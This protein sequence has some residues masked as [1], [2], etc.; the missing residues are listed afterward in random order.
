MTSRLFI[1]CLLA[2]T[3]NFFI[4]NHLK[5]QTDFHEDSSLIVENANE[6]LVK[7][8]RLKDQD[9][10]IDFLGK[11]TKKST[12]LSI[13]LI[14]FY[15]ARF[16]YL[17][18]NIPKAIIIANRNIEDNYNLNNS[19]AK[20]NNI[21]GAIY[22]LKKEY[23]NAIQAFLKAAKGYQKQGNILREHVIYNNIANIYLALGDHQQ[24]YNYSEL[25]FSEYRAFPENPNYL[26]FL[27]MLIICENNLNMLDSAKVHIDMGL[28]LLN[29]TKDIQGKII[30]NFAKSEWEYKNDNFHKAI[31]FAL[32]SLKISDQYNLKQFQIMSEILLMDIHNLLEEYSLALN[33]GESA[34]NNLKYY[35]NSSMKHSISNGLATSYAGLGEFEKAYFYKNETDSLKTIDRDV[36]NK[37]NMDSLLVEFETSEAQNELLRKEVLI[38]TKDKDIEERNNLIIF[39][40][41]TLFIFLISAI[42]VYLY[43]WQKRIIEIEKSEKKIIKSIQEGEEMER[44]RISSELHDGLASELTALKIALE[45]EQFEDQ[46]IFNLLSNAHALTRRIS[47][48]LAPLR[49]EEVGFTEAVADFIKNNDYENSISFYT[50][51]QEEPMLSKQKRTVLFRCIQEVIQN[52]MKHAKAQRIDVQVLSLEKKIQVSVEDDGIG[53]DVKQNFKGVG[54]NS[55]KDRLTAIGGELLIDSSRGNGT[56]LFMNIKTGEL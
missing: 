50:N 1:K 8:K 40:S 11:G 44:K 28:K 54:L 17:R 7:Q 16:Y 53:F 38:Q 47:H 56:S 18:Q 20:F 4:C 23:G 30:V 34:K 19:D 49:L 29:T 37:R 27:G 13:D 48:N 45:K 25:C 3:F 52:A 36:K 10:I 31:P 12:D 6:L 43:I 46:R 22:S 42:A 5:A 41:L 35:N 2:V 32:K 9:S 15:L 39:I 24:A 21:K 14:Q 26:G 55:L 51:L 33:F